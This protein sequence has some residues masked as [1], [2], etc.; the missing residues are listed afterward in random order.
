MSDSSSMSNLSKIFYSLLIFVPISIIF[1]YFFT[2]DNTL[3]FVFSIL[4]LI[5]LA[6][7]VGDT[8]E[9]LAEH[10]GITGGSLI[11]VTFSN[12]PEI[13]LSIVAVQAGLID[14]VK[15]NIIGS[16]LGEILFVLGLSLVFGGLKYKEQLFNKDTIVFHTS[17]LFLA[18]F[19][20][21][22]PTILI[23]GNLMIGNNNL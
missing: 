11:N 15:A 9:H 19:I 7:L 17:T 8:T 2:I 5:P 21:S 4:G 13:I 18:V 16:I 12:T 14:L 10:F 22:I 6:K 1:Q 20:I 3:L 23:F